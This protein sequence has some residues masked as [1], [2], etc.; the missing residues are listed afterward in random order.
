[1]ILPRDGM[2]WLVNTLI[3]L[4]IA[5]PVCARPGMS[6]PCAGWRPGYGVHGVNGGVNAIT[7]WDP[8]GASGPQPERLVIGGTF[9]IAGNS[10]V[11]NVAMWDGERWQGFGVGPAMYVQSVA[12]LDGV[13]YAGGRTTNQAGA[14]AL[15]ARWTG[16]SWETI[17]ELPGPASTLAVYGMSAH[18]GS[19]YVGGVFQN[20][21]GVAAQNVARWDGAQWHALGEGI[22]FPSVVSGGGSGGWVRSLVVYQGEVYAGGMFTSYDENLGVYRYRNIL[23]WNGNSWV[24]VGGGVWGGSSQAVWLLVVH[25]GS[26][27]ANGTFS[28]AGTQI[29]GQAVPARDIARWDG[30]R[31][32]ALSGNLIVNQPSSRWAVHSHGG[33][34]YAAGQLRSINGVIV[35]TGLARWNGVAWTPLASGMNSGAWTMSSDGDDLILGGSFVGLTTP[36]A[37]CVVRWN[38]GWNEGWRA[39][40][41]TG[42]DRSI[43]ALAVADGRLLASGAF[44][45]TPDGAA[46]NTAAYD[47]S[48]WS[49][50]DSGPGFA[51]V[52]LTRVGDQV[53][54]RG[55]YGV[56]DQIAAWNGSAWTTLPSFPSPYL[57]RSVEFEGSY[58]VAASPTSSL[59]QA[60][61]VS[62]S[63]WNGGG[64]EPFGAPLAGA[65][66]TDMIV[67][68]GRLVICG[69]IPDPALPN[70]SSRVLSWNGS[71]WEPL[72]L[73]MTNGTSQCT[74]YD[75][76]V[77]EGDL[78]AAG[79]FAEADHQPIKYI[80]RWNGT[81]WSGLGTEPSPYVRRMWV[82]NGQLMSNAYFSDPAFVDKFAAWDGH[83]WRPVMSRLSFGHYSQWDGD[84]HYDTAVFGGDLYLA[85]GLSLA[86]GQPSRYLARFRNAL[87][88]ANNDHLTNFLDLVLVLANYARSG[89]PGSIPG[90][91]NNDGAVNMLDLND[92]LSAFG[93]NCPPVP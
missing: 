39:F 86:D 74:V 71:A 58:I 30:Q 10:A 87:G 7:R 33:Y 37:S 56:L 63:R 91:C 65:F 54:A 70:T 14:Q 9:S 43:A 84:A 62:F 26:L 19:L 78:Y 76:E 82:Y 6:D 49:P 25:D 41:A 3:A 4:L 20:L 64:W 90:D 22:P 16:V 15:V 24:D 61:P 77:W 79:S 11:L 21:G 68:N 17:A 47:G 48:T 81:S 44:L 83:A 2:K 80:A 28:L 52:Q 23:R 60:V 75:L 31:W 88:D 93:Q 89:D 85:H 73:R 1:M 55:Q 18:E 72:G 40:P 45:Y 57:Q 8:D 46:A 27:I 34:L 42:F 36:N 32:H 69:N 5:A 66:I 35:N 53:V 12:V 29:G 51:P 67:W 50:T 13:L 92:V 38:E 59:Y